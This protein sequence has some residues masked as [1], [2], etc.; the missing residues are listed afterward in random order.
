MIEVHSTTSCKFCLVP[1]S[2]FQCLLSICLYEKPCMES[3]KITHFLRQ[4]SLVFQRAKPL[5]K[6][7]KTASKDGGETNYITCF[8]TKIKLERK[9]F[10]LTWAAVLRDYRASV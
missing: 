7:L 10:V 1:H 2:E 6:I 5:I 3:I 8:V 9:Y 4:S